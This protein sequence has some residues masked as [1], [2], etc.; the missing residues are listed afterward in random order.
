MNNSRKRSWYGILLVA[1][2]AVMGC[3]KKPAPDPEA[4]S[5]SV[6]VDGKTLRITGPFAHENVSVYLIHS[7]DQDDHDYLTLDQGLKDGVVK[8][9]E[10][11]QERVGELQIDN[12][13]DQ[14]L[15]LQEGDRLQ[16]GK[17][18]RT[19]IASLVVPPKSGKMPVPTFCIEQ[20]RW[21]KGRMGADFGYTANAALAPKEVRQAAKVSGSQSQVWDEVYDKKATAQA[22]LGAAN[23]NSSLNET[24]DSPQVKKLSDEC[25]KA[26]SSVLDEKDDA[27]GVAIVINGKVEEVNIYPNHKLLA[28]LY[29]RLMQSYA[30]QAA[31][32]KDEAKEAT[33]VTCAE[34][35]QF[36][37]ESKEKSKKKQDIN[38]DNKLEICDLEGGRAACATE[39]RGTV[40]H[41]QYLSKSEPAPARQP[42]LMARPALDNVAPTVPPR[43]QAPK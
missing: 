42:A 14:Y 22:K 9:S 13:S 5:P 29:P 10:R 2:L 19:I 17:Q 27:V 43:P 4:D 11:E 28:K 21:Q 24:L 12:Q 1:L 40:V 26:L 3:A 41:K 39:Y 25:A 38:G 31:L 23:T 37:T 35:A 16:G 6:E 33:P 20:S 8:I 7:E 32:T 34:V 15:F 36:M 18:D 30:F